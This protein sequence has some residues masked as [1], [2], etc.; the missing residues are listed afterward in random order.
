M[1]KRTTPTNRS[2]RRGKSVPDL[3]SEP[4]ELSLPRTYAIGNTEIVPEQMWRI[5]RHHPAAS[6]PWSGEPDRIGWT[7]AVTGYA[8][9]IIR[10]R[11]GTLS[12]Y[13]AVPCTHPLWG[14]DHGAVPRSIGIRPHAGLN[15]SQSCDEQSP[16][17][18]RV[19]HIHH[20]D[21]IDLMR[22][23]DR[24]VDDDGSR[25]RHAP[26]DEPSMSPA[27]DAWWLGFSTDQ[28]GDFLPTYGDR[29]RPSV[30]PP[31]YRDLAY[32]YSQVVGLAHQLRS[33]EVDGTGAPLP[34][35]GPHSAAEPPIALPKP[36]KPRAGKGGAHD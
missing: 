11:N 12:G 5:P 17:P 27:G 15:Y 36:R 19:C 10:Q 13:A 33:L 29:Q 23:P 26:S 4:T 6:G 1:P 30:E 9:L 24:A 34:I 25:Y 31:V 20:T 35:A 28:D 8:C 2:G 18:F 7:D 22:E 14:F 21:P 3:S 16:A 32:V